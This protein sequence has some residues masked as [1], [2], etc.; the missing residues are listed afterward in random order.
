MS[1]QQQEE[2]L[3]VFCIHTTVQT[4]TILPCTFI[5]PHKTTNDD[6]L[7]HLDPGDLAVLSTLL[8]LISPQQ[9]EEYL[10]VFC[11]H[12][13]VLPDTVLPPADLLLGPTT[14][15]LRCRKTRTFI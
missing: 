9:Q 6:T 1:S 14:N 5:C 12:T 15:A 7:S 8:S 2:Y 10:A 3:A 11:R 4:D 13:T